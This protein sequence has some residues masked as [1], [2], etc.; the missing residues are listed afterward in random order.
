MILDTI[1]YSLLAKAQLY[2]KGLGYQNVTTPWLVSLQAV[3]ATLPPN[4][5]AYQ[6]MAGCLVGSGEQGFI[7]MMLDGKMEP[8]R[9]QTTTPCFR[10]EPEYDEFTRPAFMKTELIWYMPDIDPAQAYN[11]VVRNAVTCMFEISDAEELNA[12][13]TPDGYDIVCN[14]VELG[15]YGIRKMQEH[16]WVF[17]TGL[18]EPRFSLTVQRRLTPEILK[19][20]K[21]FVATETEA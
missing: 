3:V 14:G 13:E 15:S 17:G 20:Q 5:Q 21:A 7:Q 16:L 12:V 4:S 8:G 10:D 6:T 19:Q 11:Q 2:Y 1:D 18:A 9:Y